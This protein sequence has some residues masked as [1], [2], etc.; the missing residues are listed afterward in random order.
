[1]A[2]ALLST[3]YLRSMPSLELT[4]AKL[5][6]TER[7][8]RRIGETLPGHALVLCFGEMGAGKTTLIK[9]I[10]AGLG[11]RPETVIS[12]TYTLVNVYPG[13]RPVYHVDLFRLENPEALRDLDPDDWINPDGPTLIEWPQIALELIDPA[14]ALRAELAARSEDRDARSLRLQSGSTYNPVFSALSA[15]PNLTEN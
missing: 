10:C 5:G 12:P 6:D 14:R 3:G 1:M 2:G 9:A 11:I 15:P 4:L 13:A 7:V 8:G